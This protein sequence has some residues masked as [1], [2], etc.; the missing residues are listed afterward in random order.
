MYFYVINITYI[1]N[2]V[3]FEP[4]IL[5]FHVILLCH[6]NKLMTWFF[7]KYFFISYLLT[8]ELKLFEYPFHLK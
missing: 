4:N 5:I 8:H 2:Y 6:L 3:L 1:K 7:H